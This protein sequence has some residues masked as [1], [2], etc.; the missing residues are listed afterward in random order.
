MLKLSKTLKIVFFV[1]III[2]GF[3]TFQ[4]MDKADY[5]NI[6]KVKPDV[7]LSAKTLIS[8]FKD[9]DK[10][11]LKPESVVEI[12]GVVKEINT[13][14]NRYTIVLKGEEN[15]SSSI[16]CD[17]RANQKEYITALKPKDTILIKGVFKGFL[18]DAVFLNC[19]I[20]D[21]TI[22]E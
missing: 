12:R 10:T 19:V 3:L 21:R 11:I 2:I 8:H 5:R 15:D 13:I 17:M 18:R 4:V 1:V 6:A 20:S 7:Y 22:N 14:N 16:I 9:G